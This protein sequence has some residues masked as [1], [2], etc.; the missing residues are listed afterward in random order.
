MAR[1][2][3]IYPDM[4]TDSRFMDLSIQAKLLWIGLIVF[5]DDHGRGRA[6]LKVLKALIFTGHDIDLATIG[7]NLGEISAKSMIKLYRVGEENY[8]CLPKWLKYQKLRH[9][10]NSIYP[11]F[12][13][14]PPQPAATSRQAAA[15][16]PQ[17]AATSRQV[18]ATWPKAAAT[19][20]QVA[21]TR[22]HIAGD[23]GLT[24]A[25]VRLGEV[26][27]SIEEDTNVSSSR[28]LDPNARDGESC[29][30][31]LDKEF[32]IKRWNNDIAPRLQS[33]PIR[34][35]KDDRSKALAARLK[36]NPNLWD[37]VE[38]EIPLLREFAFS[39]WVTFDWLMRPKNLRKFLEGNYRETGNG[40]LG[41]EKQDSASEAENF[42]PTQE[43]IQKLI[44]GRR[45]ER[46]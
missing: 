43:N 35:L 5:A 38:A 26:R 22:G 3:M 16:W 34:G 24:A 13:P 29:K 42:E 44:E 15:T 14:D 27:L 28:A 25:K 37:L 12:A 21:E 11:G 36:E 32:H 20:R 19:S 23:R 4:F 9:P 1:E 39:G 31:N 17:P 2:R 6:N 8:Y 10:K 46:T 18:A 7:E 41:R 40:G 45:N 33:A 30:T